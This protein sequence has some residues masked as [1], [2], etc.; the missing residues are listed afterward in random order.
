M[1]VL[2]FAGSLRAGSYNKKYVRNAFE[3]VQ[4]IDG[5]EA[6][7]L[8]LLDYP[9]PVYN[10]DIEA[11]GFPEEVTR[12]ASKLKTFDAYVISSPEN[13]GSIAA[14]LK[15][16]VDWVSRTPNNPWPG[17]AV[18]LLGASTGA[19][20]AVRGLWHSR[21]PFEALGCHVYPEMSGLAKAHEAFDENGKLKDPKA[22]E[23]LAK[24]VS[25]FTAH[26]KAF[27]RP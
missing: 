22:T 16:T 21:R 4:S 2:C 1:K 20:G 25:A 15:N 6:E 18:L 5:L 3:I 23:R 10:Q 13:N 27:P 26:A 11:K 24:L 12:L 19:L 14:L 9:M 7:F 8:D 17:R